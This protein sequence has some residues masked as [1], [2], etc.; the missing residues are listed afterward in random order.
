MQQIKNKFW[1]MLEVNPRRIATRPDWER[2]TAS[3]YRLFQNMTYAVDRLATEITDP[4]NVDG[5][6]LL[7]VDYRNGEYA[8]IDQATEKVRCPLTLDDITRHTF[9][10]NQ[11]R[12]VL[13]QVLG[14]ETVSDTV[15]PISL[16][17][18]RFG[19]CRIKPGVEFPV[20]L[21]LAPDSRAM[22]ERLRVLL[23]TEKNSFFL[24]TATRRTWTQE[25]LQLVHERGSQIVSLEECLL[26]DNGRFAKSDVWESA[27]NAFRSVHCPDNLVA[28]PPPFEF[29]KKGDTWVIRYAGEDTYLQDSI[30]LRCIGQ[31]LAKPND[32]V[33]VMELR[34]I[35]D[36]QNL[37]NTITQPITRE[38]V[39]DQITLSNLKRRYLELQ[40][41][42]DKA[43]RDGNEILE[44][45]IDREMEEIVQYLSRIKG[46]NGE[47]RK[48]SDDFEK[49]RSSTSKAFR[50]SV[51]LIRDDLPQFAT[52]LEK[53]CVVGVVCNYAP[54]QK[55][56]WVL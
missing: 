16:T 46:L 29:R 2:A 7:V 9:D 44:E 20:Y 17:P 3:E 24:L 22:T 50:R 31:L 23:T 5:R 45:E 39:A 12:R 38:D 35:L 14:F 34:A 49:A 27:V 15:P 1:Y 52:H 8:A 51:A 55:I 54:E 47:T 33:F 41:D 48:V 25:A 21:I 40:S 26:V 43:Q 6:R 42:L 36:G 11:F 37:E 53:S 19:T 28:A 10:L 4:D 18:I 32:P 30:G 56:E 13:S